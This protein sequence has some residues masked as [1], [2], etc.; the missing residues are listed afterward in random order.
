MAIDFRR[1]GLRMAVQRSKLGA[2]V[3]LNLLQ[4]HGVVSDNCVVLD[5]VASEDCLRAAEWLDNWKAGA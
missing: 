3:A 2:D 5:D 4:E 1:L